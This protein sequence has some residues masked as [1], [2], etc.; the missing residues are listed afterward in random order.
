MI[1]KGS[2]LAFIAIALIVWIADA[3]VDSFI[4]NLDI[5]RML[6]FNISTPVLLKRLVLIIL[7]NILNLLASKL[8]LRVEQAQILKETPFG[9]IISN[10][11]SEFQYFND[12]F[13]ELTGYTL[14]DLK[15]IDDWFEIVYDDTDY[16]KQIRLLWNRDVQ[17]LISGEKKFV[18]ACVLFKCKDGNK[19]SLNMSASYVDSRLVITTED[20]TDLINA[21]ES[22]AEKENQLR[23]IIDTIPAFIYV[24]DAQRN[25]HI[26]NNSV[27]D[28]CDVGIEDIV[29]KQI[30]N[31]PVAAKDAERFY[32]TDMQIINGDSDK[33]EYFETINMKNGETLHFKTIKVPFYINKSTDRFALGISMDVSELFDKETELKETS[34]HLKREIDARSISDK[35]LTETQETLKYIV[36]YSHNIFYSVKPD[37]TLN[38]MSKQ[39]E[40]VLGF[41]RDEAL[42][43]INQ[44]FVNPMDFDLV[45]SSIKKTFKSGTELP[46]TK[47]QIRKKSNEVIWAEIKHTPIIENG[48]VIAVIGIVTDVTLNITAESEIKDYQNNLENI[49]TERTKVLNDKTKKLSDSQKALTYLL[50]DVN[51]AQRELMQSNDALKSANKEL[52]AFSYSISHDLRTPLRAINSY[53]KLLAD[54]YSHLFDEEAF[55]LF[56]IIR[57]NSIMMSNLINDLLAFSK[58]GLD[59]V[60]KKQVDMEKLLRQEFENALN[61]IDR[62]VKLEVGIIHPIVGDEHL[63]KQ[64]WANL[65]TN[66]IKYSKN[67]NP[68]IVRVSSTEEGDNINYFV[69]DNGVGFDERYK[70][71]LFG[72][73]QRLHSMHEFEGTGVGLAI[74]QRIIEKHDGFVDAESDGQNGATFKFSLPKI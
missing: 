62:E 38:F 69:T 33:L 61:F 43:N 52:E 5:L 25:F 67:S 11:K 71:K 31:E 34:A 36:D 22:L 4:F 35:K 40:R 29:N 7:L 37:M 46:N 21:K 20:V 72:V 53:T 55:R 12:Y 3:L 28:F 73:F 32:E 45:V 51:V 13:T 58:L 30:S 74:V 1:K 6:S 10:L 50:E 8:R 15:T 57:E 56:N 48:D 23:Q 64:V 27:A 68:S 63:L 39:I 2:I 18:S 70:D 14:N 49:I 16:R 26:L 24:K 47:A 54:E 66:A 9:I 60:A 65:L 17:A 19:K 42:V 41:S 59:K 44:I